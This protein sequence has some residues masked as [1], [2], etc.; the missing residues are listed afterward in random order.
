MFKIL[1]A[2]DGSSYIL[3]A[4]E[5]IAKLGQ[6]IA[7]A[8]VTVFYVKDL[9]LPLLGLMDEAAL[10]ALPDGATMQRQVE[11]AAAVAALKDTETVLE[12][13]GRPVTTR[14]EWG[15]PA[16]VI[17]DIAQKEG[18]DLIVMGS[19]GQGQFAGILLGSVSDRVVH[20]SRVAALIVRE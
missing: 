14:S 5:Y 11:E 3:R 18:F 13:S 4:A 12:K 16:T 8:Q 7:D 1:L 19:R 20:Q 6:R 15:Q 9:S 10:T 2:T 17:A